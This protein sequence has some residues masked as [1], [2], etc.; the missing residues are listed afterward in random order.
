MLTLS[1]VDLVQMSVARFLVELY[2][3]HHHLKLNLANTMVA[4]VDV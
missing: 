3:Y 2:Y 4:N 1:G